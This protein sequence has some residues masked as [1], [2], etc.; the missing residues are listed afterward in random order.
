MEED[1]VT[2][3]DEI[4]TVEDSIKVVIEDK[5]ESSE[6]RGEIVKIEVYPSISKY[7]QVYP[8]NKCEYSASTS[9]NLKI[10]V[11][12]KHEG[13]RYPCSHCEYA[14]T[15]QSNLRRHILI[16]HSRIKNEHIP[17]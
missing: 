4:C 2:I 14:A 12:N 5:E 9:G 6:N 11:E 10:H 7:K 13:V 8:C 3:K 16:K 15:V 1:K 17:V